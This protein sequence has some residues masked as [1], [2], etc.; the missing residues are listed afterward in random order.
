M[1]Q[2]K[3]IFISHSSKDDRI[4]SEIC[5]ILEKH[6]LTC[7]MD[8]RDFRVSKDFDQEILDGIDNSSAF[9]LLLSTSSNESEQIKREVLYATD[10]SKKDL[11][12][13]RI[14]NVEPSRNLK[15]FLSLKQW[16]DAFEEPLELQ[17]NDLIEN[18]SE[19]LNIE[20]P[21]K[22]LFYL[23]Y[24]KALHYRKDDPEVSSQ[25]IEKATEGIC[26]RIF[27]DLGL[28]APGKSADNIKRDEIIKILTDNKSIAGHI[29]LPLGIIQSFS[30][31]I[32]KEAEKGTKFLTEDYLAPS[33]DALTTVINWYYKDFRKST[34]KKSESES[35]S[36]PEYDFILCYSPDD[37]DWIE[38]YVYHILLNSKTLNDTKP[39][40]FQSCNN[41]SVTNE[42]QLFTDTISAIK[43]SKVVF[44][45]SSSFFNGNLEKSVLAKTIQFDPEGKN[46]LVVPILRPGF[47]EKDIPI[48]YLGITP[49]SYKSDNWVINL[50]KRLGLIP[51]EISREINLEFEGKINDTYINKTLEVIRV[52]LS[53]RNE[54]SF[55]ECEVEISSNKQDLNGTLKRKTKG[56]VAEFNDLYFLIEEKKIVLRATSPG[57]NEALSNEFNINEFDVKDNNGH[58]APSEIVLPDNISDL[59]F[60][61]N[62]EQAAIFHSD[63]ISIFSIRSNSVKTI[64]IDEKLK[65]VDNYDDCLVLADW[66]GK[67]Y[68]LEPGKELIKLPI[69]ENEFVYQIPANSVKVNSDLFIAYWNG[70]IYKL[71]SNGRLESVMN[72]SVGI[73]YFTVLNDQFHVCDMD[74]NLTSY[75][76]NSIKYTNQL[77]RN[78]LGM[79][80]DSSAVIIIGENKIYHYSPSKNKIISEKSGLD[81]HQ[82]VYF[83]KKFFAIVDNNGKGAILDYEFVRLTTFSSTKGSKIIFID[84][85][86][87]YYILQYPNNTRVLLKSNKVI[88]SNTSGPFMLDSLGE[89]MLIGN[90]NKLNIYDKSYI[91]KISQS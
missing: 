2:N 11:F 86:K 85:N 54:Q 10:S 12:P 30:N 32:N 21:A 34:K 28:S 42:D 64:K 47:S 8:H 9:I 77:E 17:L 76:N 44:L 82:S 84:D 68:I 91:N 20:K 62:E 36:R 52:S 37:Y 15:Y 23:H 35:E 24:Q 33:L 26:R 50:T 60:I 65:L 74:G 45:L 69:P 66:D 80:S 27:S 13:V 59:L 16:T 83:N 79:F 88:F 73:Q 53:N 29:L 56:G 41:N 87:E 70:Y 67:V 89:K 4:A 43:G 49:I 78:I 71:N 51:L 81:N 5:S 63:C 6:G 61:H 25:Y 55:E 90:Q 58:K 40:I 1:P 3:Q 57:C 31:Y 46:D 72:H 22:D 19:F 38:K 7:C 48:G 39:R 75:H 14:E 18:L